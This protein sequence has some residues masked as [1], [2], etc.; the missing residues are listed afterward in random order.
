M[1]AL[2]KSLNAIG[3]RK[4]PFVRGHTLLVVLRKM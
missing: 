1:R 3:V 4:L 2:T